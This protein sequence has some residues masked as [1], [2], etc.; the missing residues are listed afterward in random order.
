[1][2]TQ[3]NKSATI[4]MLHADEWLPF[5]VIDFADTNISLYS[6]DTRDFH[7]L[8][9]SGDTGKELNLDKIT[10]YKNR[11][12]YTPEEVMET[13]TRLYTESGGKQKSRSLILK[14]EAERYT[15][16][17]QLKYLRIHRTGY[18]LIICNSDHYAL[19]KEILECPV[20]QDYIFSKN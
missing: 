4:N 5:Q 11:F 10:K 3:K 20:N 8:T 6:V 14:G 9:S 13:L 12:F 18:G 1:M 16:N 2:N 15:A 7:C 19:K 17:W